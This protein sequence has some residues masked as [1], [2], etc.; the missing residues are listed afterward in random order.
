MN[1]TFPQSQVPSGF[2]GFPH[3]GH[4]FSSMVFFELEL[5]VNVDRYAT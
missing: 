4:F 1:Y 3:F 5:L 2:K